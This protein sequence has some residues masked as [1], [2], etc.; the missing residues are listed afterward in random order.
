MKRWVVRS[1]AVGLAF[2][3]LGGCAAVD[4]VSPGARDLTPE[5]SAWIISD[6]DVQIVSLDG[7]VLHSGVTLAN[8]AFLDGVRDKLQV[9]P[10][11]HEIAVRMDNG[12]YAMKD[13][14]TLRLDAKAATTYHITVGYGTPVTYK[15]NP[16]DGIPT[17]ELLK[18]LDD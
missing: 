8:D 4:V 15:V 9:E 10:G 13:P 5:Q 16:Y 1:V 11:M 18:K 14:T 3:A 2:A 6:D 7:K 17:K 12:M